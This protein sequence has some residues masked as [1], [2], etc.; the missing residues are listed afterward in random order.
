MFNKS[1]FLV[2]MRTSKLILFFGLLAYACGH[3]VNDKNDVIAPIP[4]VSAVLPKEAVS[5]V[6]TTAPEDDE[7]TTVEPVA[8]E[9]AEPVVE[10]AAVETDLSARND[11]QGKTTAD[12]TVAVEKKV[13]EP[14]AVEAAAVEKVEQREEETTTAANSEAETE[15][16]EESGINIALKIMFT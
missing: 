10:T 7:A 8:E 5:E 2:T 14:T 11:R 15:K 4:A 13:V 6:T 9:K 16:P 1:F 12:D 3:P